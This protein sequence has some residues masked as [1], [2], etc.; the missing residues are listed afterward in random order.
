ML[1]H[2]ICFHPFINVKCT[3]PQNYEIKDQGIKSD[4]G[5]MTERLNFQCAEKEKKDI[6]SWESQSL[7]QSVG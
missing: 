2:S 7:C 3:G 1:L 6:A 4:L 5:Q